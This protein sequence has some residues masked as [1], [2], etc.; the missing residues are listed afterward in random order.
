MLSRRQLAISLLAGSVSVSLMGGCSSLPPE[1]GFGPS[2]EK[3]LERER[4]A[5]LATLPITHPDRKADLDAWWSHLYS[6]TKAIPISDN[7]V[8][9]SAS[10]TSFAKDDI[11]EQNFLIRAAAETLKAK[12]DGFVVMQVNYHKDGLG[13]PSLGPNLGLSSRRWIGNYEDFLEN[14]NEQN[15]FSGRK[16]IRN[17]ALDG[18]IFLVDKNEFPNRDRFSA[19]ELYENLLTYQSR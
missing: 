15:I 14:R 1:F 13:L 2:E 6:H 9:V 19:S 11:P 8:R 17:K 10:G 4:Q 5:K 7:R 18:V 12:K 3:L 16:S